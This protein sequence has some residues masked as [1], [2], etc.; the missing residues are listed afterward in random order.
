MTLQTGLMEYEW[1][2]L[3]RILNA[4]PLYLRKTT[5]ASR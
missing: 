1:T 2:E 3:G 4:V 5:S